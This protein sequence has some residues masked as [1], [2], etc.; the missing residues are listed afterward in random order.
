ML[1]RDRNEIP[2]HFTL[3]LSDLLGD[4]IFRNIRTISGMD[5]RLNG[6]F[7][8]SIRGGGTLDLSL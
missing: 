2:W 8:Y 7:F 1:K 3:A 4:G 6:S 5:L